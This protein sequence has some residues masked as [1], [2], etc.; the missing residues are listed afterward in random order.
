MNKILLNELKKVTATEIDFDDNSTKIFIPR[1]LKISNRSIK[2]GKV[3]RI[4]INKSIINSSSSILISNWNDGNFPKYDEYIVEIISKVGNMIKV[5][6]VSVEDNSSQF[7]GW[8]PN[9][10]F[11][12]ISE[13]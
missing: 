8:L 12:I 2:I 3:Y 7:F 10:S 9:D 5:N 11:E 13:E 4:L 1:S 6:G